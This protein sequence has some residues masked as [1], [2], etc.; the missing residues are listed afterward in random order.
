MLV[1]K[2]RIYNWMCIIKW[3]FWRKFLFEYFV[4]V[5]LYGK[6]KIWWGYFLSG[7]FFKSW[8][9]IDSC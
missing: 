4:K 5:V 1:S 9:L 8:V 3:V 2:L 6:G 7:I